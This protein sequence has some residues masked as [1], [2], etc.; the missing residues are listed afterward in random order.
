MPTFASTF[1]QRLSRDLFVA[2]GAPDDIA[3][4]VARALVDANLAGHDSHGVLRIP[5]YLQYQQAGNLQPDARPVV[6][7]DGPVTALVDGG[8]GF[9]QV[10]ATFAMDLAVDKALEH[11]LGAV[12]VSR[13]GHIGRVGEYAE[14]AARRGCIGMALM[15]AAGPNVG[16]AAP[17]GGAARALGTNPFAFGVPAAERPPVVVDFAT[18]TVAE[19]KIRVARAAHQPLPPGCIVDKAGRPS[20]DPEDFYSGGM[21]LTFGGH[22]GYGLS[23]VGAMLGALASGDTPD[24]PGRVG[25]VFMLAISPAAFRPLDE[26]R[27]L[28]DRVL[29][30]IKAVP[31]APGVAEVL[32]PGEPEQRSREQR[33]RDGIPVADVTWKALQEAAA[34]VGVEIPEATSS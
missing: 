6:V 14:N 12:G 31:P 2:A 16:G 3:Q 26:F 5:S 10:A 28:A 23:L 8:R 32:V 29:D 24:H 4:H 22:K 30:T 27:S 7:Q 15:G 25:G 34:S 17:F 1:L 21:L 13:C 19:G 18:T 9:G 11:G 20:T 33:L